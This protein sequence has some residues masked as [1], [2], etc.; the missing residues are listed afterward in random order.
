M[1]VVQERLAA[2]QK[3]ADRVV[4]RFNQ[5]VIERRRI[6]QEALKPFQEQLNAI[7][8]ELKVLPQEALRLDGEIRLLRSLSNNNKGAPDGKD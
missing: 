2:T 5:L 6:T 4:M 7:D 1:D 3:K 8:V